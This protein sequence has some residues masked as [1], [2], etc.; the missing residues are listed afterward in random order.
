MSIDRDDAAASLSDIANVE[1]RTRERLVYDRSSSQLILWGGL[2]AIGYLS[3]YGAP[4][5][6]NLVWLVLAGVGLAGSAVLRARHGPSDRR[7]IARNLGY[8]QLVLFGYGAVLT[9]L[10]WPMGNR[11]LAAFWPILVMFC[12]VLAG[13]WLGRF[14]IYLGAGVSLLIIA[15][16]LW[17]GS[18][19][20]LWMAAVVGGGLIA[21]GLSLRRLG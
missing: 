1:R 3:S 11:Q 14:F 10:L 18:F 5:Y 20:L 15:G 7:G 6:A 9:W 12:H 17:A 19:Y 21:S 4:A 13:L 8:A 2:V 16:Y